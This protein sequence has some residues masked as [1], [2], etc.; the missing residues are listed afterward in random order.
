MNDHVAVFPVVSELLEPGKVLRV[1]DAF[2]QE[3]ALDDFL[4]VHIEHDKRLKRGSLEL[5]D[6]LANQAN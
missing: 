1:G 5:C 2:F 4:G 3:L 6:I